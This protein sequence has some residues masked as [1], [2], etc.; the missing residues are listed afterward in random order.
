MKVLKISRITPFAHVGRL[1]GFDPD[2]MAADALEERRRRA[3]MFPRSS[4]HLACV[5][6]LRLN[7]LSRTLSLTY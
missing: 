4:C 5:V 1:S 2:L 3:V 7:N 6:R